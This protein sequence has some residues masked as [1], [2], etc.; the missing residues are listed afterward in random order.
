MK[1]YN[2]RNGKQYNLMQRGLI[3]LPLDILFSSLNVANIIHY[4]VFLLSFIY[5]INP[6]ASFDELWSHNLFCC[7]NHMTTTARNATRLNITA[8]S[9]MTSS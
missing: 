7:I 9:S 2:T 8:C 4:I 5:I 6:F 1:F 3:M